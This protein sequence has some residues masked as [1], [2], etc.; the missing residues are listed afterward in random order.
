MVVLKIC[1]RFK[2]SS[3]FSPVYIRVT[4]NRKVG[5]IKTD[6]VVDGK[7]V[8]RDGSVKDAFVVEAC[9]RLIADYMQ[10]L[11]GK[12]LSQWSVRNVI[13]FLRGNG[14]SYTF[15]GFARRF[16]A[17]LNSSNRL[18]N[19][20]IYEASLRSL[21]AFAGGELDFKDFSRDLIGRWLT[22]LMHT[23]RARTLY[24]LCIRRI[25]DEA[26]KES[27]DPQSSLK[28][29]TYNPWG[30]VEIP[31]SEVA[32][33]KA[34]TVDECR[35]F[36][37]AVVNER[38]SIMRVGRDV[39]LLSFCLAAINTADLFELKKSDLH[40]GVLCYNRRKTSSRRRDGAYIEMRVNDMAMMLIKK[41]SAPADSDA[42]LNF[43]IRYKNEKSFN[44]VV[45]RGIRRL[46]VSMGMRRED[47]FSF[48]SFRHTWATIAQNRCGASLSEIGFAMNHVQDSAV[49]R[50]YIKLDFSPAWE[51]NERVQEVV[52]G[53]AADATDDAQNTTPI[54]ESPIVSPKAMVYARAYF[55]GELLGEVSD[56]G[57]GTIDEVVARLTPSVPDTIPAGCAVQFRIKNVDAD[58]EAM[59]ERM[60]GKDF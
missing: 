34:M 20:H 60:K 6:W 1:T 14:V 49:T 23:R 12:D 5:Y 29:I 33:K 32:R 59:Y 45:N 22:S 26:V 13:D 24:P 43:G 19:A 4:L 37:D 18:G 48:Y 38:D 39:A 51:L 35:I 36:F 11:N 58:R 7:G 8:R 44:S 30:T 40:N 21:E 41:Y 10:R 2:N 27:F 52:F 3:G 9:T 42:L 50:G 53:K 55:R 28:P 47:A 31:S 16:I 15:S 46:C 17:N 25:F 56:I 57:F 54:P